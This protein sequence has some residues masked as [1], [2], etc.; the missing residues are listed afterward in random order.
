M[1]VQKAAKAKNCGKRQKPRKASKPR[2]A[3]NCG[4]SGITRKA[5]NCRKCGSHGQNRKMADGRLVREPPRI[6]KL[7][8][9]KEIHA[10]SQGAVFVVV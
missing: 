4:R 2:E 1:A 3:K 6:K 8:K 9:P 10:E 7:G 5:E